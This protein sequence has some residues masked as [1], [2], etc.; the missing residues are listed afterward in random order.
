MR[1]AS[2]PLSNPN[3]STMYVCCM[4]VCVCPCSKAQNQLGVFTKDK[5]TTQISQDH[6]QGS[7]F[8]FATICSLNHQS[9]DLFVIWDCRRMGTPKSH[10]FICPTT[11]YTRTTK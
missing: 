9:I 2:Y 1:Y 3:A 4:C 10:W 8:F 6:G 5:N 7:S 11:G